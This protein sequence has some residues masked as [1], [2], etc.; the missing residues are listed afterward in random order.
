MI[1]K[2]PMILAYQYRLRLNKEQIATIETWLELLRKQY[3]YRLFERFSWWEDNRNPINACPLNTPIP[4]LRDN[5]DL[6][7]Q[8]RDLVNTKQNCNIALDRELNAAINIKNRAVGH[9]VLKARGVR[10]DTGTLK[11][12]AHTIPL[13]G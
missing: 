3:N 1:I 12:E 7:A 2:P 4:Q 10:R 13:C 8:K 6:T 11:R 5:P 9:S